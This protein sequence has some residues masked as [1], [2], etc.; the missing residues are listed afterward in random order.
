MEGR[1]PGIFLSSSVCSDVQTPASDQ[2]WHSLF[3]GKTSVYYI[4]SR[5]DCSLTWMPVPAGVCA[6]CFPG[7][8]G[9]VCRCEAVQTG[10]AVGN[11]RCGQMDSKTTILKE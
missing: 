9:C 3:I 11:S 6:A 7:A 5:S 10:P 4:D 2:L 8:A 1:H